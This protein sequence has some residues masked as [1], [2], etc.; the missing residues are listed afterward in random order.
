MG[1]GTAHASVRTARAVFRGPLW[2]TAA[3]LT[4]GAISPAHASVLA[5]GTQGLPDDLTLE[6]EPVLLE[7]ASRLDPP[8]LRRVLGHLRLVADAGSVD[9]RAERRHQR[10]GCG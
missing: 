6:A 4:S 2:V 7:A 10:R 8:R 5:Y 3:A 9:D 1:A